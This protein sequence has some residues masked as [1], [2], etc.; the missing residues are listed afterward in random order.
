MLL[1]SSK[2]YEDIYE[3]KLGKRKTYPY[4]PN[5]KYYKTTSRT[6]VSNCLENLAKFSENSV[7]VPSTSQNRDLLPLKT[8]VVE[9]LSKYDIKILFQ[10][11]QESKL[12]SEDDNED[13]IWENRI[14]RS[15]TASSKKSF[16][17]K[18]FC[19]LSK[20]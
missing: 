14:H 13:L 18:V 12:S 16:L 9:K 2:S 1:N 15:V 19:C 5:S 4:I 11:Q 3:I 6:I 7:V 8:I 20:K 17:Q 10:C